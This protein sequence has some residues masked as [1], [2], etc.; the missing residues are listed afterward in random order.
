MKA[1]VYSATEESA[2][3]RSLGAASLATRLAEADAV[4]AARRVLPHADPDPAIVITT[5]AVGIAAV[6]EMLASVPDLAALAGNRIEAVTELEYRLW[7]IRSPD[8]G[9]IHHVNV[10]NWIKTAIPKQR[11]AE[12]SDR[13]VELARTTF[14]D[15][16]NGFI[17]EFFGPDWKPAAGDAG[18]LVEPGHQFEWAWLLARYGRAR[19][20][21]GAMEIARSLFAHGVSGVSELMGVVVDAMNED[22]SVRS[23]RARLWPQTEWMKAALIL[24][25]T[26][27]D[28]E[29]RAYLDSAAAAQRALWFYLTDDGLWRDKRLPD[30][31]FIDEPAPASSFYHIMAAFRQLS[32]TSLFGS[33]QTYLPALDLR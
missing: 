24:A 14:I 16:D 26:S 20:D 6:E 2:A 25:E 21:A 19:G 17:R 15:G 23:R 22:G 4:R 3:A 30:R 28:G 27:Q 33:D 1:A 18:R 10:W 7:C 12:F 9:F 13:I 11:W 5:S 32:N 8:E 29:R 31:D